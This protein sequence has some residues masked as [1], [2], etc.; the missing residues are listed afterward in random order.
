LEFLI[1]PVP[2]I[3][4]LEVVDDSFPQARHKSAIAGIRVKIFISKFLKYILNDRRSYL[5]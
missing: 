2:E 1:D 4:A 5:D 3:N